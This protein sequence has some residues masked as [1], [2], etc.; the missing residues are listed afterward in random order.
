MITKMPDN[1]SSFFSEL[2]C[3]IEDTEQMGLIELTV[4]D[5]DNGEV[6][7][8]RR[9]ENVASCMIDLAPLLRRTMRPDFEQS[10]GGFWHPSYRVRHI[11]V[12][13]GDEKC[14]RYFIAAI[15]PSS[16]GQPL[17]S[18]PTRRVI[19]R[20]ESDDILLGSVKSV[21]QTVTYKNGVSLTSGSSTYVSNIPYCYTLTTDDFTGQESKVELLF[22][23]GDDSQCKIEYMVVDAPL[24]GVRVAWLGRG[25]SVERYTFPVC[26]EQGESQSSQWL[27]L[28]RGEGRFMGAEFAKKITLHT[29]L[30]LAPTLEAIAQIGTSPFVAI[31]HS[32]NEY[33]RVEPLSVELSYCNQSEVGELQ[34][35]LCK[36]AK[37][38]KLW[39]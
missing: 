34:V 33:I 35:T 37:Q 26:V 32:Q 14:E 25:G 12:S 11:R 38:I 20:G 23:L 22:T 31:Q 19:S 36:P 6:L 10:R 39:S 21:S 24:K 13:C 8:R 5:I 29:A 2:I 16:E 27:Q 17:T 7:S 3:E 15:D 28:E 18:M 9:F 1:G 30:E 4:E